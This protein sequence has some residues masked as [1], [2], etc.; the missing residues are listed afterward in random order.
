ML[1]L[2]FWP[3]FCTSCK[4]L[5]GRG[6]SLNH[7]LRAAGTETASLPLKLTISVSNSVQCKVSRQSLRCAHWSE[8]GVLLPAWTQIR[9]GSGTWAGFFR[10]SFSFIR[11]IYPSHWSASILRAVLG[12]CGFTGQLIKLLPVQRREQGHSHLNS[13]YYIFRLAFLWISPH[14]SPVCDTTWY[15]TADCLKVKSDSSHFY[16]QPSY[17]P[18]TAL[19][20]III[21]ILRRK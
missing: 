17:W 20:H 5:R 6:G 7:I 2:K 10:I 3:F 18:T 21:V 19:Y 14:S 4:H 13:V 11:H 12:W 16:I 1:K 15:M 8:L 9:C